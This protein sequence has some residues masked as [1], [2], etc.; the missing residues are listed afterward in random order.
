MAK[1]KRAPLVNTGNVTWN[2]D[3]SSYDYK[4]PPTDGQVIASQD[5]NSLAR[6]FNDRL[7]SGAG[8]A[9]WRIFWYAHG[10]FRQVRNPG[11]DMLM[12]GAQQWPAS[13]EW[14]KFYS[15][16][17]NHSKCG[18]E[19]ALY[20]PEQ[21]AGEP[22][23]ANVSNPLMAYYFGR[24]Y[25]RG[26]QFDLPNERDRMEMVP[27]MVQPPPSGASDYARILA[28]W[29]QAKQQRG[30]VERGAPYRAICPAIEAARYFSFFKY[31]SLAP[32]L[33]AYSCYA[34]APKSEGKCP[35]WGDTDVFPPKWELQFMPLK[36]GLPKKV[37]S[38]CP[39]VAGH[40]QYVAELPEQYILYFVNKAPE[41]LYYSDYLRTGELGG[42]RL[43]K[44]NG[45]QL[46][47][48]LNAFISD[49]RGSKSARLGEDDGCD[50]FVQKK[51]FD[52][53]KFLTSQYSLAPAM[54]L[55]VNDEGNTL[56]TEG[57]PNFV[58]ANGEQPGV[59]KDIYKYPVDTKLTIETEGEQHEFTPGA[60][61][62][63]FLIE[64][65][66]VLNNTRLEFKD[67][68][69]GDFLGPGGATFVEI[70]ACAKKRD[71]DA[72]A[73]ENFVMAYY[74]PAALEPYSMEVKLLTTCELKPE[75]FIRIEILEQAQYTPDVLDAYLVLRLGTGRGIDD[76]VDS[77]GS[78]IDADVTSSEGTNTVK[79]SNNFFQWGC[80]YNI[81]GQRYVAHHE[82]I[83][84]WNSILEM[85]REFYHKNL[86]LIPRDQLV[87]YHLDGN[88]NSVLT[89]NRGPLGTTSDQNGIHITKTEVENYDTGNLVPFENVK[90]LRNDVDYLIYKAGSD[91]ISDRLYYK[92]NSGAGPGKCLTPKFPVES[93]ASTSQSGPTIVCPYY[94][95]YKNKK[96]T[97]PGF[98]ITQDSALGG[99]RT[100]YNEFTYTT[101]TESTCSIATYSVDGFGNGTATTADI[102]F[103]FLAESK[104]SQIIPEIGP[105]MV[106]TVNTQK[107]SW[108]HTT[109]PGVTYKNI[110]LYQ[111]TTSAE[112]PDNVAGLTMG[113]EP[114]TG[115]IEGFFAYNGYR[116]KVQRRIKPA[117]T[118]GDWTTVAEA[119][120][121]SS[122]KAIVSNSSY[123]YDSVTKEYYFSDVK[124]AEMAGLVLGT[125]LQ[126]RLLYTPSVDL[127]DDSVKIVQKN[128]F[129][130]KYVTWTYDDTK[131]PYTVKRNY[132]LQGSNDLLV[133]VLST[134]VTQ[135]HFLDSLS[136]LAPVGHSS[137]TAAY[138][139]VVNYTVTYTTTA[140]DGTKT[141]VVVANTLSDI[142]FTVKADNISPALSIS[143]ISKAGWPT[144]EDVLFDL[145]KFRNLKYILYGPKDSGIQYN[146]YDIDG[147]G[148][149]TITPKT[150]FVSES[151]APVFTW[152]ENYTI[153]QTGGATIPDKAH[154]GDFKFV[155]KDQH[156]VISEASTADQKCQ[157]FQYTAEYC[158]GYPVE[159]YILFTAGCDSQA[160]LGIVTH[161]TNS[162]GDDVTKYTIL[163]VYQKPY[164]SDGTPLVA[165]CSF[166]T[167]GLTRKY[168]TLKTGR[169]RLYIQQSTVKRIG[170]N[171][172]TVT[173]PGY[174]VFSDHST[175]YYAG[176]TISLDT[177]SSKTYTTSD[178][179]TRLVY[180]SSY[181]CDDENFDSF[182]G[183]APAY[184]VG[185]K[186]I[187]TGQLYAVLG[188]GT[189]VT[190]T[191]QAG[192]QVTVP[193]QSTF[194]WEPNYSA[195]QI[196]AGA[197]VTPDEGIIHGDNIPNKGTSNEWTMFITLNHYHTS[198]SSIW[199]T[200]NYGDVSAFL[201]NRCL[202]YSP[203]LRRPGNGTLSDQFCYGQY[204]PTVV[205]APPGYTYAIG[206]SK[207]HINQPTY[208]SN[209]NK[210]FYR[211]CQ[212]YKPDY[213]VLSV[214]SI[215]DPTTHKPSKVLVTLK[216]RLAH[217]NFYSL[218]ANQG[219]AT[220]NNAFIC[221]VKADAFRTDENA[222][223]EY[224]Y[225]RVNTAVPCVRGMTGDQAASADIWSLTDDPF[226]CCQPRFYFTRQIPYVHEDNN[227][228][229]D[230]DSDTQLLSE[231]FLQMEM[232]L[233]A[234][235]GGYIDHANFQSISCENQLAQS[236][237]SDFT[238]ENLCYQG[239]RSMMSYL[240]VFP[241]TRT[242]RTFAPFKVISEYDFLIPQNK[243]DVYFNVEYREWDLSICNFTPW[244]PYY[245]NLK[246]KS[247]GPL[248][249][250]GYRRTPA[251]NIVGKGI[252]ATARITGVGSAG[253]ITGV[254][255]LNQGT[256]YVGGQPQA[257]INSPSGGGAQLV[258]NV[259]GGV[260]VSIGLAY[261]G[262]G[263][264]IN[265]SGYNV[266]DTID[267]IG[268]KGPNAALIVHVDSNGQIDTI[269]IQ[270]P[271]ACYLV[272]DEVRISADVGN[273]ADIRVATI[274]G[275][276]AV[277]TFNYVNRGSGYC[278]G[279]R[280][281]LTG[282]NTLE[283]IVTANLNAAGTITGFNV[284]NMGSGYVTAPTVTISDVNT[285]CGSG[286]HA[287]AELNP[288]GG[289]DKVL[290]IP[291]YN[292]L[293]AI[294]IEHEGATALGAQFRFFPVDNPT[295]E[296]TTITYTQ[297]N[298]LVFNFIKDDVDGK[299]HKYTI[300]RS[301]IA[302]E[303]HCTV[304]QE[305]NNIEVDFY[306]TDSS[307]CTTSAYTNTEYECGLP[308]S[309][310][311]KD[312][313]T[314]TYFVEMDEET[315][316]GVSYLIT[317]T[318]YVPK[319]GETDNLNYILIWPA[320][321]DMYY[322]VERRVMYKL[323]SDPVWHEIYSNAR[324][325]VVDY[326]KI[327]TEF[328]ST[329]PITQT[330]NYSV[331]NTSAWFDYELDVNGDRAQE[332]TFS[333]LQ[334]H[335]KYY[336]R[337][338][339]K[340]KVTVLGGDVVEQLA[341]FPER[342]EVSTGD[343]TSI[344]YTDTEVFEAGTGELSY[345]YTDASYHG[346]QYVLD[347]VASYTLN[348]E[349]IDNHTDAASDLSTS[350]LKYYLHRKYEL[351]T[352]D[353][354][355]EQKDVQILELNNSS[356]PDFNA[357]T[358]TFT[359]NRND[360]AD[361]VVDDDRLAH[362]SF[363][364][365]AT[366]KDIPTMV[367]LHDPINDTDFDSNRQY[368]VGATLGERSR[369]FTSVPMALNRRKPRGF[370]PVPNTCAYAE[371]F[372]NFSRCVNLLTLSRLELPFTQKYRYVYRTRKHPDGFTPIGP[373][374]KLIVY[375]ASAPSPDTT[376]Y[377]GW[378]DAQGASGSVTKGFSIE[379]V[380]GEIPFI[381]YNETTME[382]AA[383][384]KD[385]QDCLYA[386]PDS[387]RENFNYGNILLVA[388]VYGDV[389]RLSVTPT[390]ASVIGDTLVTCADFCCL[391]GDQNKATLCD[392]IT[393]FSCSPY[394]TQFDAQGIMR[395]YRTTSTIVSTINK[396]EIY[397]G[398]TLEAPHP[399]S[400]D[401][402]ALTDACSTSSS[403]NLTMD[404]KG[405]LAYLKFDLY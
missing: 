147:G 72:T 292:S 134:N 267:I 334:T 133:K 164:G 243:E 10:L 270:D 229:I 119:P 32:Y 141:E 291:E 4:A 387:L 55:L 400:S 75:G 399:V 316:V 383:L 265:G 18:Q 198:E 154:E 49:F 380:V 36:K 120:V 7:K 286:A 373:N 152:S 284:V 38:T 367:R 146:S 139:T 238:F 222:I 208:G 339:V 201:H 102:T 362:E 314:P 61:F 405:G 24:S 278:D 28:Y 303:N 56:G 305:W 266:S 236:P 173:G 358:Y 188:S 402:R 39:G 293:G 322:N 355:S 366:W 250:T 252:T 361:I 297:T 353:T 40:V 254:E 30:Y 304:G 138:D 363:Y 215:Y 306:T 81:Y 359:K 157:I 142:T 398:G 247:A 148:N 54:G 6:A 130:P 118:W 271:G 386:I 357:T 276:G 377:S 384:E 231:T 307:T 82:I 3:T 263:Q 176:D 209:V 245:S 330:P 44:T 378:S 196:H 345:D 404:A 235:C 165:D 15:H 364:I 1:F 78:T 125:T 336:L 288:E 35:E 59:P 294:R 114:P 69:T 111:F 58:I 109:D 73:D 341:E 88:G 48:A 170:Q 76:A 256:N 227:L 329:R 132:R 301:I 167:S 96:Y 156:G 178:P 171:A 349:K 50:Y 290:L 242:G 382:F 182:N 63:G 219:A 101:P 41:V 230:V 249:G 282:T 128:Y 328:D 320:Q 47:Q 327:K 122:G 70:P 144:Q 92:P 194:T 117:G 287:I 309:C 107:I 11:G 22:E 315:P 343:T 23:G 19:S 57:Y 166:G 340:R 26:D 180:N 186:E 205:E 110:T 37:Y 335:K 394:L 397:S 74:F 98:G 52:F 80:L 93:F 259:S 395:Y 372:N 163:S 248:G 319:E 79:F 312:E 344:S 311:Y 113:S 374:T 317:E 318:T 217:N 326:V 369:W 207:Y 13:D 280:V 100:L 226:G 183:I 185:M 251:A 51:A 289:I 285:S 143:N 368:R 187:Q 333:G 324:P 365:T 123:G 212:V 66:G 129:L 124:T 272:G 62:G 233:R 379:G 16:V 232:Y 268:G 161:P 260:V 370:G 20:W 45:E 262:G 86:R 237:A 283:A 190:Y 332:V 257:V 210:N 184:S 8:D 99:D 175:K 189:G 14:W 25:L 103:T 200:S 371:I 274:D 104:T 401:L 121:M 116:Y 264:P 351:I 375:N 223:L 337:K 299:P 193:P 71:G 87:D 310:E 218:S 261:D 356:S 94:M 331:V 385:N 29:N 17:A 174:I 60:V 90:T 197:T 172:Y 313:T 77:V 179:F 321:P 151:D 350:N 228:D 169:E 67:P 308:C 85:S 91:V 338:S 2:S 376:T 97:V 220:W 240:P 159:E 137:I 279:V 273:G 149:V 241:I 342:I 360:D 84:N 153:P 296:D 302:R 168:Y 281:T 31:T 158:D 131:K 295:V 325:P 323:G 181:S 160:P 191:N 204:P 9:T 68:A 162:A 393:Y 298:Y 224:L 239:C 140:P 145:T 390:P 12:P 83:A 112:R 64:A 347:Q 21:G 258:V 46:H 34:P 255:L 135:G 108:I 202:T 403:S 396:C 126:Y 246:G 214:K 389:T 155:F 211:S 177:N 381:G 216:G 203:H 105:P 391:V 354:E 348:W 277:L 95:V 195:L 392:G 269:D 53:Q 388:K 42:G 106:E 136:D 225:S 213:E 192:T 206:D 253:E 275:T 199:K 115:S 127:N 352:S 150:V 346:V 43:Q 89:F 65:K 27:V 33:K 221:K 244:K 300:E 5:Y 234:M